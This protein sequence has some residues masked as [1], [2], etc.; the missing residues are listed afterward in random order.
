MIDFNEEIQKF[1]PSLEVDQA[2]EAIFANDLTDLTDILETIV[3]NKS[4]GEPKQ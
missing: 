1:K 2:E 3:N 4:Q